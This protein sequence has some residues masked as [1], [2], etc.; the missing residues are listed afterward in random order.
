MNLRE[1]LKRAKEGLEKEKVKYALIGGFALGA[2][3]IH[4]ATK[5]IDLLVDGKQKDRVKKVLIDAGFSIEFESNEV[6]QFSGPGYLDILLANRPLSL[7]MLGKAA[8]NELFD[9]PVIGPE[10][11][12]GLKIQAYSNDDDRRFQDLADIQ[13]LLKL[14]NLNIQKIKEYAELFGKWKEIEGL[15]K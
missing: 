10:G 7:E 8:P 4:R 12:I 6:M 5:D 1:T 11:I 15:I 3:G 2:H 9:V 14:P 13:E